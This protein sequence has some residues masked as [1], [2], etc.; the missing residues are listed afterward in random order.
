MPALVFFKI[1][2]PYSI[3]IVQQ[4]HRG[5]SPQRHREHR[6]EGKKGKERR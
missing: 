4:I 1:C 5:I 3:E 6:E 2:P